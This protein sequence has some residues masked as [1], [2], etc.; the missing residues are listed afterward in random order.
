L[1]CAVSPHL[2]DDSRGGVQGSAVPYGELDQDADGAVV[3][4]ECE[5]RPRIEN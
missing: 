5:E 3:A 1:L 4:L 2:P